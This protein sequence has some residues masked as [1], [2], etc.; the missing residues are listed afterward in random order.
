[1]IVPTHQKINLDTAR[2]SASEIFRVEECPM[3]ELGIV[4]QGCCLFTEV[5]GEYCMDSCPPV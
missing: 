1:M 5:D 2:I 4:T 3:E